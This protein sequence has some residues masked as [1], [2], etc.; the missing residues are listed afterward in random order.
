M[1]TTDAGIG[2]RASLPPVWCRSK[3]LA[4]SFCLRDSRMPGR[5]PVALSP[6]APALCGRLQSAVRLQS[7]FPGERLRVSLLRRDGSP[8]ALLQTS[9]GLFICGTIIARRIGP[10]NEGEVKAL[11]AWGNI[12]LPPTGFR[13]TSAGAVFAAPAFCAWSDLYQANRCPLTNAAR[14]L[15]SAS[16]MRK[17]ASLPGSSEPLRAS[18]PMERAG[19][20]EAM[21]TTS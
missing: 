16:V 2:R 19:Y 9:N 13:A 17:S 18:A 12:G 1:K 10:V 6:S 11:H 21:F 14:T 5:S 7:S 15:K 8:S 20:S 4:L 3:K